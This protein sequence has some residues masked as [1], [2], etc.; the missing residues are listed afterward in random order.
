M[1]FF[2]WILHLEVCYPGFVRFLALA[3]VVETKVALTIY[4]NFSLIRHLDAQPMSRLKNQKTCLLETSKKVK[5]L[6]K[7]YF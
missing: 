3:H 6:K 5:C 7:V 1:R 4:G 2:R